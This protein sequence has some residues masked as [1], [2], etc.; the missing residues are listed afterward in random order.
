MTMAETM[1]PT[2]PR[3]EGEISFPKVDSTTQPIAAM[4]TAASKAVQNP[5]AA[6]PGRINPTNINT[7]ADTTR[8]TMTPSQSTATSPPTPYPLDWITLSCILSV[9]GKK[10]C[11]NTT[12]QKM[13]QWN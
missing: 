9:A 6:K 4:T 7:R 8:R 10:V 11:I 12:V 1:K 3:L 2:R 5:I 13:E